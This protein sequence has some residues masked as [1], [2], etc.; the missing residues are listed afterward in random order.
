DQTRQRPNRNVSAVGTSRRDGAVFW[1]AQNG[2]DNGLEKKQPK[3]GRDSGKHESAFAHG[4]K[5]DEIEGNQERSQR[6]GGAARPAVGVPGRKEI[7]CP[8]R[9][10]ERQ[11]R[12]QNA[13][14]IKPPGQKQSGC[15][16]GNI[17]KGERRRQLRKQRTV[18]ERDH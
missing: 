17:I 10:Q 14:G 3:A 5:H 13:A 8:M 11:Q 1:P 15:K 18:D 6:Y 12:K 4:G 2:Y 7:D 16:D 9:E